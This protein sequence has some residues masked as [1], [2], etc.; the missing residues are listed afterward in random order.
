MN[1]SESKAVKNLNYVVLSLGFTSTITQIILLREF[2]S[3]F[4]G[5]ELVIGIILGNWMI[6]TGIGSYLGKYSE[7]IKWQSGLIILLGF[8]LG[9]FPVMT[10]CLLRFLRNTIFLPGE[11]IGIYQIIYSSFVLLLPFCL[12]SGFTFSFL[13]VIA[14]KNYESNIISKVYS[15]ESFG[16]LLGGFIFSVVL[17]FFLSTFQS[18]KLLLILNLSVTVFLMWDNYRKI[19]RIVSSAIIVFITIIFLGTDL[20]SVTRKYL[21]PY[22]QII[23]FKDTPYGNLAVTEQGE[24]KNF[25]ENGTLLFSTNDPATNEEIVHYGMIQHSNPKHVLLIGGGISGTA[26][27]ILKYNVERIDY[28]EINPWI[29]KAGKEFTNSLKD[30]RIYVINEDARMFVRNASA[31]YDVVIINLPEPLTAQFNRYYTQEFF[32]ELKERLNAN[33]VISLSLLPSTDYISAKAGKINSTIYNT[34]KTSFENILIVPGLKNFFIVSDAKLNINIG[35]MISER[36]IN[37]L[38]VNQYYLDDEVLKQ[39]SKFLLDQIEE[40]SFTNKDFNPVSYYLQLI[41]WLDYFEFNY[42][43]SAIIV[44]VL[45]VW[46]IYKSNTLSIGIFCVGFTASSIEVILLI[47]FQ[48]IYG[49]VYQVTGIIITIFMAGLAAGSKYYEKIIN[50]TDI[51]GF[52][53]IQFYI[54]GY[55]F[56]LPVVL[57]LLNLF[58]SNI[59]VVHFIFYI[60]TFLIAFLTGVAFALATKIEKGNTGSI[61]AKLYSIDLIGSAFGALLVTTFLIPLVGVIQISLIIGGGNLIAGTYTLLRRKVWIPV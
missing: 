59:A 43:I 25:F 33:A 53:K 38:Y 58:K 52:N 2:L 31:K 12:V 32:H 45:L 50:R 19:I 4:Y 40:G 7:K 14:S 3:V 15:I 54:A 9:L 8:L 11:M 46:V 39:R 30:K 23:F 34:L 24:Q 60:L 61:V 16:S 28:V 41:H 13:S 6:I 44:L 10:V 57:M 20:D 1:Y 29:I 48:I 36:G 21:F 17:I 37:N 27:E 18:L 5:N 51:R 22:Q 35:R 26:E 49:Y 56:L 55:S 47:S 42:W